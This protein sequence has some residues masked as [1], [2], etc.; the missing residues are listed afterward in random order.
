MPTRTLEGCGEVFGFVP[1]GALE[2]AKSRMADFLDRERRRRFVLAMLSDVI[3]AMRRSEAFD[4]LGVVTPDED[5]ANWALRSGLVVLRDQCPEGNLNGAVDSAMHWASER[6]RT[7]ISILGDLPLAAPVEIKD[8][9][10]RARKAPVVIVPDHIG[11]GTAALALTP[12]G[13]ISAHFGPGSRGSHREA[14]KRVGLDIV[15]LDLPTLAMDMDL[16]ADLAR[17]DERAT[18]TFEVVKAL[19]PLP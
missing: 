4:A 18:V 16:P 5:V 8:L 11:S 7:A 10:V 14:A 17:L 15:E 12:P 13:R 19:S 3:Q 6:F 9:V 2:D 1:I